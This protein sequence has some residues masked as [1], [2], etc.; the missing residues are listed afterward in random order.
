M[1]SK[2]RLTGRSALFVAN[3]AKGMTQLAAAEAAGY[4][5][6]SAR[7]L[8]ARPD[9]K[10]AL[11]DTRSTLQKATAYDLQA[12]IDELDAFIAESKLDKQ[13]NRQAVF[14]AIEAKGR[15][16]GHLIERLQVEQKGDLGLDL[17]LAQSR[18]IDDVGNVLRKLEALAAAGR[19]SSEHY[20]RIA[21]LLPVEVEYAMV[22]RGQVDPFSV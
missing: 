19:L 1:E 10:V 2:S 6:A 21:K 4:S 20:D 12:F 13:I 9:I 5:K 7:D 8:M 14:K 17:L 16:H 15:A 18:A 11:A 3:V 22:P